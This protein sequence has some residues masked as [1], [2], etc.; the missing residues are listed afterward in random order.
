VGDLLKLRDARYSQPLSN[1]VLLLLAL[2]FVLIADPRQLKAASLYC[3]CVSGL[4]LGMAFVC[5][6]LAANP[7]NP[8]WRAGWSAI[9]AWLPILI[10]GPLAAV[11]LDKM[12][13]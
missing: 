2:P 11:L 8:A 7:P 12:K 5:F 4:F 9:M 1:I 6:Q 3:V 10:F 13:T